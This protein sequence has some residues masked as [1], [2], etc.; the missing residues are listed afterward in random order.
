MNE[1]PA[2]AENQKIREII[3]SRYMYLMIDEYQDTNKLQADIACSLA[4]HHKNIMRYEICQVFHTFAERRLNRKN[5]LLSL[6]V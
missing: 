1:G 3:A 5:A 6:S 2:G 4:M